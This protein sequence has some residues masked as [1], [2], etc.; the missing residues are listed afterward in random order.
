[1]STF[2]GISLNGKY[3]TKEWI[4]DYFQDLS[5]TLFTENERQV[6]TFCGQWLKG[7]KEYRVQTS[8]STGQPKSIRLKRTQMSISA[9]MTGKALHLKKGERAFVCLSCAYIG[10]I[11][12]LVRGL[13]LDLELIVVDPARVPIASLG[14]ASDSAETIESFA[15]SSVVPLQLKAMLSSG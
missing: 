6:L 12:M 3:Y 13:V 1:M 7:A 14:L 2:K 15:L 5:H 8:G 11:M 10:G 9:R 4:L